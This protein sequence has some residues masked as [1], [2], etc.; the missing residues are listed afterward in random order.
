PVT[1]ATGPPP[2]PAFVLADQAYAALRSGGR[3]EAA[4]LF[5]AALILKPDNMGWRHERDALGRRLQVSAWAL[6]RDSPLPQYNAPGRGLA[7]FTASPVLGGGQMGASLA[8]LANPLSSRP[9]ALVARANVAAGISGIQRDTAQAAIGLRK[10]LLPGITISAERLVAIG[11]NAGNDWTVRLAAGGRSGRIEAYGEAG[12]LARG[13][14]YGGGQAQARLLR[15]G[16]V[17][18]GAGA[19]GSVQTERT[20]GF[21]PVWRVDAGPAARAAWRGLQLE[22][23]WR[24]RVAG[25]ASPGSGPVVTV[26]ARF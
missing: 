10:T 15:I 17:D 16:P 9:L 13:T 24:Q 5:D 12:V 4:R 14:L 20:P 8:L 19:W 1:L 7:N 26:A 18:I 21:P 6:L 11:A 22:A 25:N 23:Q 3:R 2:D